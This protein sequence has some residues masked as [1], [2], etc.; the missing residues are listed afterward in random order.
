MLERERGGSKMREDADQAF[1][2]GDAVLNDTVADEEG[3]DARTMEGRKGVH[4]FC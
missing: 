3:L 2:P 1:L 4:V